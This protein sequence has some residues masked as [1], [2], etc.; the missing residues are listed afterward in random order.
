V[1]KT[2][3]HPDD[4]AARLAT[5]KCRSA[6]LRPEGVKPV[7]I[8]PAKPLTPDMLPKARSSAETPEAMDRVT[9]DRS[10]F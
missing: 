2:V 7:R 4:V 10:A 8:L 5:L 1:S 9:S 3:N 6:A